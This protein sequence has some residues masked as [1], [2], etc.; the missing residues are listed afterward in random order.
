VVVTGRLRIGLPET[1]EEI[2]LAPGDRM[3][4]PAET[5]HWEDVVGSEP[6]TYFAA[7]RTVRHENG[8]THNGAK[9]SGNGK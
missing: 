4:V 1:G 5:P 3:D 7:T 9:P 2:I 8:L 6:T